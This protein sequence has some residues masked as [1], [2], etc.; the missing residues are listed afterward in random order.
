MQVLSTVPPQHFPTGINILHI[1]PT[2]EKLMELAVLLRS[3]SAG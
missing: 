3:T 1:E 2:V